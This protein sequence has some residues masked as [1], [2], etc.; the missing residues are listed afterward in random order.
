MTETM[1]INHPQYSSMHLCL[2]L[3]GLASILIPTPTA[4]ELVNKTM[5]H[6]DITKYHFAEERVS[7]LMNLILGDYPDS[8]GVGHVPSMEWMYVIIDCLRRSGPKI[9]KALFKSKTKES[10]PPFAMIY[11]HW[12]SLAI[13]QVHVASGNKTNTQTEKRFIQGGMQFIVDC[14]VINTMNQIIILSKLS[15]DWC[16]IVDKVCTGY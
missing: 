11:K 15:V 13:Y 3:R 1:M 8:G 6:D 4:S 5:C 10:V 7:E 16:Y 2:A 14:N 12:L 9:M